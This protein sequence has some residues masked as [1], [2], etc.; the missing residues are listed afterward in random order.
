MSVPS[1]GVATVAGQLV[2]LVRP[3]VNLAVVGGTYMP[4]VM[5]TDIGFVT[6]SQD[7]YLRIIDPPR[8][9]HAYRNGCV[10]PACRERKQNPLVAPAQPRQPWEPKDLERAA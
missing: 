5:K 9:C 1:N 10:C 3:Q 4:K 6:T 7:G 2:D 8:P